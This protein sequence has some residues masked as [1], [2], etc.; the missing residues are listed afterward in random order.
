MLADLIKRTELKKPFQHVRKGNFKQNDK[1]SS[2]PKINS[3]NLS[4]DKKYY[5]IDNFKTNDKLSSNNKSSSLKVNFSQSS[6]LSFEINFN[7]LPLKVNFKQSNKSSS[8][9]KINSN[10][11]SLESNFNSISEINNKSAFEIKPKKVYIGIAF[12]L[13]DELIY[14][15]G[16][17]RRLCISALC[18]QYIFRM[19]YND[20]QH[21]SKNRCY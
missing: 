5:T 18:D 11:Q 6:K 4:Q 8:S 12:E 9:L 16:E 13:N 17:R 19:V 20:N 14:Y 10:Q 21:S 15:F 3:K 1:S 7:Q 2:S